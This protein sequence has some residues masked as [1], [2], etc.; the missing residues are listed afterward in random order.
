MAISKSV[1]IKLYD[2]TFV[3]VLKVDELKNKKLILTTVRDNQ[4]KN[5]NRII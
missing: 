2:D 4:K 5:N 3:P 1:G